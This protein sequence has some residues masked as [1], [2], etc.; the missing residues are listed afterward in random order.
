M[1]Y[2]IDGDNL[3]W[4]W[5]LEGDIEERRSKL[6]NIILK[7]QKKKKSKFVVFFDGPLK[8]EFPQNENL[9]LVISE[10]GV[11]A[12]ELFFGHIHCSIIEGL[13]R[14]SGLKKFYSC[15]F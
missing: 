10:R 1:P 3:L 9:K 14:V 11:S 12:D 5:E 6:L 2:L 13:K 7:F 8:E 15:I 4:V